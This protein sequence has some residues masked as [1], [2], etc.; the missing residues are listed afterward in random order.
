MVVL[1]S[2]DTITIYVFTS[3]LFSFDNLNH[4]MVVVEESRVDGVHEDK[5]CIM[6][7]L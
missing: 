4:I 1:S 2:Q 3:I 7:L 5:I 6:I